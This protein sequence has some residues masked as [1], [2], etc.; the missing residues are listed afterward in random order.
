MLTKRLP[1]I[2]SAATLALVTAASLAHAQSPL[3]I[4]TAEPSFQPTGGPLAPLLLYVNY[5]QQAFYRALTGALKAMRQDPWQLASLIGLSFAYGVFHAA[6]PGHG[7]AVISSYMIANEVEL[8]RGVVISFISAFV[9]GVVAVALVGGA[10]L[11]LRG[12]GITL[13]AATHAMEIASFVMVILFGGWLL[14]RKLRSLVGN[15]PRRRLMATPAGPVSMMLDWKNN[16]AERQAYAFNGKA[17][18][19]EA[20]HTFVPGMVCETCGNAHVPD[21]ALLGGDRF[22]VREAWSAIVAVG[23]RPCSGALLVMTFSLLNGLYLGGVLS[24]AAMSLGTAIT[25]SLL[26]TLAV[27]AKSAAVRLS[28][29]GSTASIWIGNAIEILGAVLVM[30]MGAL[31]LGASLQG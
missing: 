4:G 2:L 27:T 14:F 20:G 7:K 1:L 28:G 17:Q 21:P 15:M 13:T 3:G 29:R 6:G 19:V 31:L 9:Q 5:E 25:V 30:L 16:A 11:V 22:S 8:K 12:T 24:V 18:A 26:A 23:L 10:W